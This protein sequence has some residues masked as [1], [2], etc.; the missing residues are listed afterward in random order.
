MQECEYQEPGIIEGHS[1]SLSAPLLLVSPF[2]FLMA[3]W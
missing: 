2:I 3:L 1:W